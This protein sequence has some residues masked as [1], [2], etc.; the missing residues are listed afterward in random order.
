MAYF[1]T[2]ATR[3]GARDLNRV[4][5]RLAEDDVGGKL[6]FLVSQVN[7]LVSAAISAAASGVTF[8][9]FSTAPAAIS[10]FRA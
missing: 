4:H 2:V 6:Q 1:S 5:K 3:A 7:M 8:S 10:N 9:A